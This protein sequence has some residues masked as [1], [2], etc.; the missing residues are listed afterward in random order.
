MATVW[1]HP[2]SSYWTACYTN[3]DGKQVKRSTKSK[4]RNDALTIALEWERLEQQARRGALII[5][6]AQKVVN[7]LVE[8]TTGETIL[9]PSVEKY[10]NEWADSKPNKGT[11]ERYKNTVK[12]FLKH[13]G[14]KSKQPLTAITPIHIEGF[15]KARLDAGV[16]PKTAV[17]DVKSLSS[18]FS[19]AERYQIILKNPVRAVPLPK[20]E[21]SEREVFTHEQVGMMVKSNRLESEWPTLI[22]LG[23]YIGAR[24]SDCVHM[25]WDNVDMKKGLIKYN[26]QKTGK[27]VTI[28]IHVQLF[29]HLLDLINMLDEQPAGFLCPKLALKTSGGKHGLSEAFKRIVKR[30]GIDTQVVQ[31]K[32]SRKFSKLTF[33]SLRHSFNSTMANA[34]ISAEVR[35]KL[36]G[37]SSFAMN[38]RYTHFEMRPLQSA[39]ETIPAIF[40]KDE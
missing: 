10:L 31:G 1:K 29:E 6:Q 21:S 15:L 37:H 20:H 12:L 19:R 38:N 4:D 9:A 25:R 35:M 13:L 5:A 3:K 28:P 24:L 16:A 17:I 22:L 11:A 30:A 34:G 39:I 32:G 2:K 33:H 14:E 26:Q 7:E 18:A 23:Y 27:T 8:K 36:T 40:T